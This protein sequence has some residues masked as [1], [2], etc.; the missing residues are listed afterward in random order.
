MKILDLNVLL[1]A[2]NSASQHH[3]LQRAFL[4]RALNLDEVVA[5]PWHTLLGFLRIATDRRFNPHLE[6]QVAAKL[7]D[8]WL[9]RPH[10]RILHPGPRHWT[11]LRE[12]VGTVP[13]AGPLIAD[14][15][16]AA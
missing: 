12:L 16:L 6:P 8:G 4:E 11:I 13:A 9:A 3:R 1:D 15:H 7:I 14:A 10:V 2:F 5:L